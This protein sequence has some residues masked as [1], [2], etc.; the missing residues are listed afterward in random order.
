MVDIESDEENAY[1]GSMFANTSLANGIWLGINDQS[2]EGS[3]QSVDGT[4]Q[5]YCNWES[6][7]PNNGNGEQRQEDCVIMKSSLKWNDV[8]C[9]RVMSFVCERGR[10]M[11]RL[12]SYLPVFHKN[13]Q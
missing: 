11:I 12:I 1:I 3:F 13:L 4:E 6:G 5:E 8:S 9:S 7:E 2:T 10:V